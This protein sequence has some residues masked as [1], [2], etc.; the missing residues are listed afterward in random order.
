MGTQIETILQQCVT[1]HGII[2]NE[3]VVARLLTFDLTFQIYTCS[4]LR[5]L[6]K[7]LRSSE[8]LVF[9]K[10]WSCW[11]SNALSA[12]PLSSSMACAISYTVLHFYKENSLCTTL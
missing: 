6:L 12:I 7:A 5:Y 1:L 8:A 10:L 4:M 11:F 3:I 9:K 2:E